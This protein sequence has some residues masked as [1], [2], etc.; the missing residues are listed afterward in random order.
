MG[1]VRLGHTGMEMTTAFYIK[2]EPQLQ[3]MTVVLIIGGGLERCEGRVGL[4]GINL[5][6]PCAK[7]SGG[8]RY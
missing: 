6:L 5:Q 4:K 8:T 1:G 7:E 2:L 3:T